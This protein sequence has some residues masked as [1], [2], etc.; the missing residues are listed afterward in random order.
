M[1]IQLSIRKAQRPEKLKIVSLLQDI[2]Q[3]IHLMCNTAPDNVE[4]LALSVLC[5]EAKK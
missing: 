3:D 4:K 1:E 5:H 2:H